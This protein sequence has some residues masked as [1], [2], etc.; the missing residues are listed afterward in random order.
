LDGKR[1]KISHGKCREYGKYNEV[2]NGIYVGKKSKMIDELK[3]QEDKD[4]K[5]ESNIK[6]AV[7]R[8]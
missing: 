4:L 1:E 6:E 8:Y 2:Q 5:T 7:G 3:F